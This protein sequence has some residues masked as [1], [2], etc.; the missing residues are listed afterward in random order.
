MLRP[1]NEQAHAISVLTNAPNFM[2]FMEWLKSL[3]E[4][5][6]KESC[7]E[8]EI[9]KMCRSQGQAQVLKYIF[10]HVEENK[11]T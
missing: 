9:V 4:Y 10:K 11:R 6:L 1:N 8:E 5:A 2:T 7:N 3:M